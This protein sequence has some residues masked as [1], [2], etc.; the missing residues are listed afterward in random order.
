VL[1]PAREVAKA[2]GPIALHRA[3]RGTASGTSLMSLG[4]LGPG[5]T[6]SRCSATPVGSSEWLRVLRQSGSLGGTSLGAWLR[7]AASYAS[8]LPRDTP[9][10]PPVR[11]LTVSDEQVDGFGFPPTVIDTTSNE[12]KNG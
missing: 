6:S 11:D 7:E 4:K 2:A 3:A 12:C 10:S 9:S 1:M 5:E 8:V